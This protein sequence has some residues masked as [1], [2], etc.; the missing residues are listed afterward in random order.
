M[1]T[2]GWVSEREDGVGIYQ[3]CTYDSDN[4]DVNPN[5]A[6][7]ELDHSVETTIIQKVINDERGSRFALE[8]SIPAKTFDKIAAN[9][10]KKRSINTNKYS[11]EELFT[12]CNFLQPYRTDKL[13][14]V[15][16]EGLDEFALTQTIKER[17][18]QPEI[19][20]DL[21]MD[22]IFSIVATNSL[23]A[24]YMQ[25]C[26]N[27]LLQL[28]DAGRKLSQEYPI[29]NKI[30]NDEEHG[31]ALM[32]IEML[33]EDYDKNLLLIDALSCSIARYEADND[34]SE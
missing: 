29:L 3:D 4:Y 7:I 5:P 23:E 14:E 30:S 19:E 28:R 9:W 6:V 26:S 18:E 1:S 32:M 21:E 10:C 34:V 33:L 31:K 20:A 27:E 8:A 17:S 22:N 24:G 15:L 13:I 2:K 16:E 25:E 11:L 12:K